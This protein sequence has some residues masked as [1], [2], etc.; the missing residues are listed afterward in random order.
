MASRNSTISMPASELPVVLVPEGPA[1]LPLEVESGPDSVELRAE[2]ERHLDAIETLERRLEETLDRTRR[3]YSELL[4]DMAAE[5]NALRH[6]LRELEQDNAELHRAMGS[7]PPAPRARPTNTAPRYSEVRD[8]AFQGD[9][10]P[11][12]TYR[13]DDD[14]DASPPTVRVV[15][16]DD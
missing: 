7:T 15:G 11:S 12:G 1:S 8:L 5:R 16:L 4:A 3:Q 6:A 13:L 2:R 14:L 9:E 10:R